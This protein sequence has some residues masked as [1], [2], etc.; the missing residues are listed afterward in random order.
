MLA[1]L[2]EVASAS[3]LRFALQQSEQKCASQQEEIAAL[4]NTVQQLEESS[5][6][7]SA[8]VKEGVELGNGYI[9]RLAAKDALLATANAH[10]DSQAA[11]MEDLKGQLASVTSQGQKNEAAAA[12]EIEQLKA[13]CTDLRSALKRSDETVASWTARAQALQVE[14]DKTSI[15]VDG[16]VLDKADAEAKFQSDIARLKS[17]YDAL[18]KKHTAL[19]AMIEEGRQKKKQ[20]D[21][22]AQNRA[23][24]ALM[25]AIGAARPGANPALVAGRQPLT[26]APTNAIATQIKPQKGVGA[27]TA[28]AAN[29]MNTSPSSDQGGSGSLKK[30]RRKA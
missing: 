12:A 11:Q 2:A 7:T 20:M 19:L 16:L 13:T 29:D 17:Q 24:A 14:L 8:A 4:R 1:P 10:I 5:K 15:A 30:L 23:N 6:H 27:R 25:A 26:A 3:Q 21:L 28:F 18:N 9:E 22:E